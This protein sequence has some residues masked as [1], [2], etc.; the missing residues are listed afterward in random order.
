MVFHRLWSV[1]RLFLNFASTT[2]YLVC[3]QFDSFGD[4]RHCL[5]RFAEFFSFFALSMTVDLKLTGQQT[6]ANIKKLRVLWWGYLQTYDNTS[7][8]CHRHVTKLTS[9]FR[10]NMTSL[11]STP[12]GK[13]VWAKP[14]CESSN[15]NIDMQRL[16]AY[17]RF[18][19]KLVC[20]GW[21]YCTFI[22]RKLHSNSQI[23]PFF[24][25][26]FNLHTATRGFHTLVRF[27]IPHSCEP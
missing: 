27:L 15:P 9:R 26:L 23:W 8:Q 25:F 11:K 1:Q 21:Y 22:L 20:V 24:A 13:I 16:I 19:Y 5:Q 10:T 12:S 3:K 6:F 4:N 2:L 17:F 7:A 18:S 14:S